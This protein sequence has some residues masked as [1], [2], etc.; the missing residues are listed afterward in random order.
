[1]EGAGFDSGVASGTYV[2]LPGRVGL[3]RHHCFVHPAIAQMMIAA[4]TER[5]ITTIAMSSAEVRCSRNGLNPMRRHM[6]SASAHPAGL[7]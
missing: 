6:V 5:A 4:V 3:H 7:P 2:S 1:V